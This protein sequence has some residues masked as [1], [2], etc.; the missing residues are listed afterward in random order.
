MELIFTSTAWTAFGPFTFQTSRILHYLVYFLIA[1]GVGA[2]GLDRGLLA[3]HGKLARRWPLWVLTALVSFA[4]ASVVTFIILT[5]HTQSQIWAVARAT[6]F[7]LSCAASCFAFLAVFLRFAQSRS[8]LFDSLSANSYAIYLLHYAFV[9]WLQY[10][11]LPASLPAV[12]KAAI[13]FFGALA[14]SWLLA[15]TIRR[16]PAVARLV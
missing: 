15:A 13:V 3:P 10:A 8:R 12:A 4:A 16:V 9:S 5:T 6:G 14:L 11:L 7:V 2:C 1:V